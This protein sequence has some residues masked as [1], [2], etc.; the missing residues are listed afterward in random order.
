MWA[1]QGATKKAP[2]TQRQVSGPC[3]G[4][5]FCNAAGRGGQLQLN[6]P[7][8]LP[9]LINRHAHGVEALALCSRSQLV[10]EPFMASVRST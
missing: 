3:G 10:L 7:Q 9:S 5:G 2:V 1:R 6:R 8:I 4:R